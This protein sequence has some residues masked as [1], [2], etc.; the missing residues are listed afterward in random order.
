MLHKQPTILLENK[1]EITK[2]WSTAADASLP[3]RPLRANI[4]LYQLGTIHGQKC[5]TSLP[6]IPLRAIVITYQHGSIHW[7]KRFD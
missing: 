7:L 6:H 5:D 1:Y 2:I 3:H 4:I